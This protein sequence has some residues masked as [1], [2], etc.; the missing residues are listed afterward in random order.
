MIEFIKKKYLI[1][2]KKIKYL[3]TGG[4]N[5]A[6][7][8]GIFVLLFYI[9]NK[10]IHYMLIIVISNILSI[11]NAYISYK[12]FVFKTKGNYLKEY[13]KFYLVYGFG[14]LINFL[15]FPV[16]LNLLKMNPYLSQAFI[17]MIVII[18]SYW[19]HGNFTFDNKSGK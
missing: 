3:I 14:I 7:G 13:L 18:I 4:W 12:I 6:F 19:A 2:Q 1:H 5:T 9:F 17:M 11:T 15:L 16:F 10:K 8:Y